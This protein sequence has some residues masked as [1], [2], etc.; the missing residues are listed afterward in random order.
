VTHF[1]PAA[2]A[3]YEFDN[4]RY[5]ESSGQTPRRWFS[6]F[7]GVIGETPQN[8][9]LAWSVGNC[10]VLVR[11]DQ[12]LPWNTEDARSSA[13]HVALGGTA[14]LPQRQPFSPAGTNAEIRRIATADELW[15]RTSGVLTE[16]AEAQTIIWDEFALGYLQ[17]ED[18]AVFIAATHLDPNEFRIRKVQDWSEYDVDGSTNFPLSALRK[19]S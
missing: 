6:G 2:F 19:Y 12:A 7:N 14:L 15:G 4:R 1:V 17:V 16:E 13:A 8:V 11:T 3:L 9:T 18:N 5:S 10:T